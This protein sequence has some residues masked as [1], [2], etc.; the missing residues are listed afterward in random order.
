MIRP[1]VPDLDFLNGAPTGS[2]GGQY[3]NE[4]EAQAG[5]T[6]NGVGA[7][8][9]ADWRSATTV[10]GASG[11]P[12]DNLNFS[13]LGTI[14]FR[15]FDFLGQQPPVVAR[16]PWLRGSRVTLNIVNLFDQRIRVRGA[17]GVTPLIYQS[18]YLDPAGRTIT[19]SLRKLFY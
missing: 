18:A 14:N 16:F 12:G 6:L 10:T 2:T 4:I 3:R 17:D 9:S 13:D 15:V 7:R 8:L 1:G 11:V 19:L 5:F